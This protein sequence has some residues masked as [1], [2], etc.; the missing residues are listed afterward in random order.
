[1]PVESDVFV[2]YAQ[3]GEDVVLFRALGAVEGGRYVDVG[4]N[5]PVADS[6]TYAFYQRGWSGIT[7]DPVH[8]CAVRQRSERPRDVMVEAAVSDD[9]SGSVT[10]HQIADTGLSTLLDDVGAEHRGAGWAVEDVVVPARRLDDILADAGWDGLEIHFMVIDVEGAERTVLETL[11]LRRWRPWVMVVEAT[12]PLT[13]VPTHDSWESI[14]IDADY[15][16]CVFDG[17]SRFYLAAERWAD[18]HELLG[19]PAN[20]LDRYKPYQ[21]VVTEQENDRLHRAAAD[22]AADR[23]AVNV[24]RDALLDEMRRHDESNT[25]A[26]LQWR[27][28][29]VRAWA[30]AASGGSGRSKEIEALRQQ[31]GLH[32]NHIV[33]VDRELEHSRSELDA[34]RRT[35]SWRIT[36]PLRRVRGLGRRSAR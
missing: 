24:Q 36:T 7:I 35:L 5:D 6:V 13:T 14:L 10:L 9:P 29:A 18:L 34:I 12:R 1:V 22:L 28:A 32:V 20:I 33:Q 4:A 11:D 31:I 30:A 15:R 23:D 21:V 3:N 25:A 17:L 27:S 16:F 19:A 26:I 2:S 8:E